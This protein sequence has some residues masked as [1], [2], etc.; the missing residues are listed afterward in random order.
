MPNLVRSFLVFSLFITLQITLT[1]QV[2][3]K[4][5][6]IN[7][8][9]Q[10]IGSA[11]VHVLSYHDST[12]I[13][14]QVT[15][16]TG[17]FELSNIVNGKYLLL[18][19]CAGYQKLYKEVFTGKASQNV[20]NL[21]FI[22]MATDQKL[23]K[24]VVVTSESNPVSRQ[25][26]KL[27][28]SV[29]GNKLFKTATNA[30]DIFKKIPGLEVNSDG[31]LLIAGRI[32]P[33]V[34][35][36]GKPVAMSAEELQNY[37]NSLS[38]EMIASVE[39]IA[40]PS[41]KYDAEYK[42]I[43]DIKLKRDKTLGW[44]GSITSNFQ[45]NAYSLSE[46]NLLLT[47]KTK[48][49]TYTARLGYTAGTRIYRYN[50]LQHLANTNIMATNT[51]TRTGN[52]NLNYQLGVDYNFTN[53]QHIEVLLRAYQVNRQV[54]SYNTLHTTDSLA[55]KLVSYTQSNNNSDPRQDNYAINLNYTAQFGN[56]QLQLL[57]S[58]VN[59]RNWQNEDIQNKNAIAGHLLDYWKTMLKNDILI[60]T[61]QVD[62]TTNVSKGKLSVG[63]R[64]ALTTTDNDLHYDTLNTGD[65]FVTDSGRTN[66]FKYDEYVTAGYISYERKFNKLNINAGLRAEH[67]HTVANSITLNEVTKRNY[68]TWLPSFNV[69]YSI[70]DVKQLNISIS[71]RMTRPTFA[72]LNPFRFYFSPLNYWVG[73]PYLLPSKTTSLN[74]SYTQKA[75]T[76]SINAGRESDPLSRY[77]EYDSATNILE[78]LGRNL[79]YNNFAGIETSF[80]ITIKPWWRTNYNIGAYYKKEQTPYHA[81][82]YAI[83]IT[84]YSFGTS[85]VFS[86]PKNFTLDVSYFYRSRTGTGLYRIRSYST[87]D[88]GLQRSWLNG[89]LNSK[90]NFYD[91]FNGYRVRLIFREK[92]IINNEF[93]HWV[94]M[95]RLSVTV[96]Y[97]FG[98]STYKAKQN[99]KNEEENRA[100]M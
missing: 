61:A 76:V 56:K 68:I 22:P 48:K 42:G 85:Q 32:T 95:Q 63:A 3:I 62:F 35:I 70:N 55:Q 8:D 49:L 5:K 89:K 45:Q 60:R 93:Q 87:L 79:P 4:G 96:S 37:L 18:F 13:K 20:L 21:G 92:S 80:P 17:A 15:D 82:T 50:A 67:T 64:F 2:V 84:H 91:I 65:L 27:I 66:N 12:L 34:F 88:A 94:G 53:N 30:F 16:S 54:R 23:L 38:P 41:S 7:N 31:T 9:Q 46:N 59:I 69:T 98:K 90:L 40:N 47:Y 28:V 52:N 25:G 72:Q 58:M 43:I 86:L 77:P 10:G 1:A 78:Y 57:T 74:I 39:V 14:A 100:G 83:P 29:A 19:S 71:R 33:T 81:V 99:N 51:Q 44:K 73:N 26:D 36:D 11:T 24:E 6:V 97:S 75:F